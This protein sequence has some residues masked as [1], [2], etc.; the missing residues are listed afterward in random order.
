[1]GNL[2]YNMRSQFA[3]IKRLIYDSNKKTAVVLR[4]ELN[5]I[6]TESIYEDRYDKVKR[7]IHTDLVNDLI[8][9]ILDESIIPIICKTLK[10]TQAEYENRFDFASS[11]PLKPTHP[12]TEEEADAK[13]LYDFHWEAYY[14]IYGDLCAI[15]NYLDIK[16]DTTN[17]ND[18]GTPVYL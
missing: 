16:I 13:L 12:E 7:I 6:L 17:L 9:T 2:A 15:F 14:N 11:L 8:F 4:K 10:I 5:S 18:D 1:M 3:L